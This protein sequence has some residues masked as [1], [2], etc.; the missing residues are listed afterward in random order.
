M[1]VSQAIELWGIDDRPWGDIVQ[2]L[3]RWSILPRNL[4]LTWWSFDSAVV[5]AHAASASHNFHTMT[6]TQ[7]QTKQNILRVL[8]LV[9]NNEQVSGPVWSAA[10]NYRVLSG[11][12]IKSRHAP[13]N[14][15]CHWLI[16][17][18]HTIHRLL[19][20]DSV[21]YRLSRSVLSNYDYALL[22]ISRWFMERCGDTGNVSVS[23]AVVVFL[24]CISFDIEVTLHIRQ[25]GE[26]T[27]T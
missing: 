1:L 16:F 22:S 7:S 26:W 27:M 5:N 23:V 9:P 6:S 14:R 8:L 10:L 17:Q 18:R 20:T 12:M 2:G 24:F 19:P 15:F 4:C 3:L 13:L 25:V 11:R 21:M